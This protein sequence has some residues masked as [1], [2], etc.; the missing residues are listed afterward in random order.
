MKKFVKLKPFISNTIWAGTKLAEAK[1]IDP[2]EKVGET[3]EISSLDGKSSLIGDKPLSDFAKLT[4]LTKFID[5]SDNLSVQVHPT[6]EFALANE[7]SIGKSEYWIILDAKP[8]SGIFLGF[9]NG[10][11]KKEFFNA[12]ESQLPVQ[13]F[14]NYIPVRRGDFFYVPAGTVHSIGAG[15]TLCEV[16]QSSGVTYRV[17]DWNRLGSN[18][19]PRELHIEKAKSV[20]NFNP[21]LNDELER[22]CRRDLLNSVGIVNLLDRADFKVELY[23][24]MSQKDLHINLSA[25]S[26]IV[27]L[28]GSISG[29]ADLKQYESGIALDD[30]LLELELSPNCSFLIVSEN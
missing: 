19:N 5:T 12:V 17:W 4:Y 24:N 28:S 23:S 9:K 8:D 16:Q 3:W 29:E 6:D 11:T 26:S 27:V 25:K 21:S 15:I 1:A 14:L 18:G 22:Y 20:L 13:N 2:S 7:N 10:V 30:G